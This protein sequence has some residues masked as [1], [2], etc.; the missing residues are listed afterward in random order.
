MG[1]TMYKLVN[2]TW[3]DCSGVLSGDEC[4]Q[5]AEHWGADLDWRGGVAFDKADGSRV[6]EEVPTCDMGQIDC[7]P[8]DG[9][10]EYDVRWVPPYLRG[11]AKAA[12][13][14]RGVE[15]TLH[16]CAACWG[17]LT[18][19]PWINEGHGYPDEED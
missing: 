14:K 9:L 16:L 13:T 1:A 4:D 5:L 17:A 10:A 8:C 15:R 3:G 2:E 19:D 7:N 12:G 11:T 18:P 6:F